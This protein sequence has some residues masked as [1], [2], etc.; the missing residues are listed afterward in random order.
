MIAAWLRERFPLHV[1][2]TVSGAIA[3]AAAGADFD[4]AR[5]TTAFAAALLL[6]LQFRLWDDL[7]DRRTDR[8][9]HPDRV[10]ARAA[11]I[12]PLG[13]LCLALATANALVAAGST[14]PR[15]SL[16]VLVA[17]HL[18]MGAWYLLRRARTALGD[19]ILLSKYP[20]FVCVLS[21]G[22]L[23][24]SPVLVLGTAL[25][26]YVA[27]CVYEAA[28]DPVSPLAHYVGGRS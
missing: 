25:V 5:L 22:R 11:S 1:F 23:L 10:T 14:A 3:I 15:L 18:M 12:A 13:W 27:A 20:A 21:G 6:V 9:R 2:A 16:G 8:V 28:H 17:L 7:A 4:T 24:E 26:I 19:H